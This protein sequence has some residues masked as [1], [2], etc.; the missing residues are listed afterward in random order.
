MRFEVLSPDGISIEGIS[1]R[2]RRAALRA[3]EQWVRRYEWQGFYST[4][5][6][7]RIPLQ[8]LPGRCRVLEVSRGS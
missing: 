4:V 2:S 3:L 7:E 1:Y 8:D 5:R 6:R